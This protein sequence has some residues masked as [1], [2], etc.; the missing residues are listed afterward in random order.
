MPLLFRGPHSQPRRLATDNAG[1][2]Q[3]RFA[4]C[5]QGASWLPATVEP[6]CGNQ[7][8]ST[9]T[10]ESCGRGWGGRP[11]P[12]AELEASLPL[13]HSA[14]GLRDPSSQRGRFKAGDPRPY[15]EN[16]AMECESH[17]IWWGRQSFSSSGE[18][19]TPMILPHVN[20]FR[21]ILHAHGLCSLELCYQPINLRSGLGGGAR[22]VL[23]AQKA[24]CSFSFY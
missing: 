10:L 5:V 21:S 18:E 6:R 7:R 15:R 1:Q 12:C 22:H 16:Q 17:P 2:E 19:Q 9:S 3:R 11:E 13:G 23:W 20:T 14:W 4:H 24:T 8:L